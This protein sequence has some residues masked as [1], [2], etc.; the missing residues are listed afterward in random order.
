MA[1]NKK[2]DEGLDPRFIVD[3]S[4]DYSSLM[5]NSTGVWYKD[6]ANW[7]GDWL[8]WVFGNIQVLLGLDSAD[9]S[10]NHI[11]GLVHGFEKPDIEELKDPLSGAKPGQAYYIAATGEYGVIPLE[12]DNKIKRETGTK[13]FN[14]ETARAFPESAEFTK[15]QW[16]KDGLSAFYI[17][18]DG[19]VYVKQRASKEL[20]NPGFA[21]RA[22]MNNNPGNLEYGDFAKSQGAIGTDG[23]FAIFPDETTGFKAMAHLLKSGD[24][25]QGKTIAEGIAT[26]A[27]HNENNV[28]SY[29]QQL[30]DAGWNTNT[31][32]D[33][34]N[35]KQIVKLARDMAHVEGWNNNKGGT[36]LKGI[37]VGFEGVGINRPIK[38]SVNSDF[39]VRDKH[40]VHGDPSMHRGVDMAAPLGTP[41]RLQSNRA[42]V[43]YSG[44]SNGY[45][46][47]VIMKHGAGVYSMYAHLKT[48]NVKTGE[49]VQPNEKFGEVGNT[50][51]GTGSHLHHEI[52][53]QRG[54]KA[55]V[56][57]PEKAW[58]KDLSDPAVQDALIKDAATI[59]RDGNDIR[60]SAYGRIPKKYRYSD[61]RSAS[62]D[63]E[64]VE[65]TKVKN[66][67][68]EFTKESSRTEVA[69]LDE[70]IDND[71][72]HRS[73]FADNKTATDN[74]YADIGDKADT[75][76]NK[77]LQTD[78]VT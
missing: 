1:K 35:E 13:N 70:T 31:K 10:G 58:G 34:L 49:W 76:L 67:T 40:P 39:E 17:Q 51:I 42:Q 7:M 36:V 69:S 64:D 8:H 4:R 12:I 50:G 26:F 68:D 55:Y 52:W 19:D 54:G 56:V 23:R 15:A 33:K 46:K 30:K 74:A 6:V 27:P 43:A 75:K 21:S 16:S 5:D 47:T 44:W 71:K 2:T 11:F 32:L 66:I 29:V 25:Y 63:A 65:K 60:A 77:V 38:V 14:F 20:G 3:E 72:D 45:G 28:G 18:K 57:D 37:P 53:I 48:S 22:W 78:N 24:S 41:L 59:A 9:A 73:L 61:N 62:V